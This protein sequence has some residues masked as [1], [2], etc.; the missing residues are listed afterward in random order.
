MGPRE[1]WTTCRPVDGL[2]VALPALLPCNSRLTTAHA[3]AKHYLAAVDAL[4]GWSSAEGMERHEEQVNCFAH[5]AH[6]RQA[7][8]A[9]QDAAASYKA[10]L[11]V[12]KQKHAH[13]A[14]CLKV[15]GKDSP[16]HQAFP[17]AWEAPRSL[18]SGVLC[19]A[20]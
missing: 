18:V 15:R 8:A 20:G 5:V 19:V 14:I 13:L 16:L 2:V 4:E 3:Q 7:I 10:A 9:L 6:A 12:S 11:L 1:Q 17:C